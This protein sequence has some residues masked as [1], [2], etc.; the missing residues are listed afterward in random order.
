MHGT[1]RS[2]VQFRKIVE[3]LQRA[4]G[5]CTYAHYFKKIKGLKK[6]YRDSSF[7]T[8]HYRVK[9]SSINT[10]WLLVGMDVIDFCEGTSY[11]HT[12]SGYTC[13]R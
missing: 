12:T 8:M 4:G 6:A 13:E 11:C 5:T 3:E 10:V 1:L 9:H 7:S 2:E